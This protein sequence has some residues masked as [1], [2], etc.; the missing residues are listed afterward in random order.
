MSAPRPTLVEMFGGLH[1]AQS[2]CGY[3]MR[4][5]D[6]LARLRAADAEHESWITLCQEDAIA[7][8]IDELAAER[9][10]LGRALRYMLDYARPVDTQAAEVA[11][12]FRFA[13]LLEEET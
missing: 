6:F 8:R 3:P 12:G 7:T 9:D 1:I 11:A 2:L 13:E 4:W 10:A 5:Y